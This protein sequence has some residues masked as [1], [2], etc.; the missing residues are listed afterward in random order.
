MTGLLLKFAETTATQDETGSTTGG[1]CQA[2][3]GGWLPK[4]LKLL[5]SS[6]RR[7]DPASLADPQFGSDTVPWAGRMPGCQ[8][9]N[10]F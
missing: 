2:G 3:S 1:Y 9:L 6:S 7:K 4:S 5:S 10:L 8:S